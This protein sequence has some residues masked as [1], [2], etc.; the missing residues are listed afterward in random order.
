MFFVQPLLEEIIQSDPDLSDE[1]P[2]HQLDM[3]M[4]AMASEPTEKNGANMP[5]L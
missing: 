2:N 5:R 3:G 4:F 1:W